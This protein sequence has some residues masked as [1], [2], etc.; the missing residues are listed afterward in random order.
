MSVKPE[1]TFISGIHKHLPPVKAFHREKMNNPY[2]SGT[3][4]VWYSANR[5]LWV[6]YKFIPKLPVRVPVK[7]GLSPLQRDWL[8]RRY[9]EGRNVWVIVGHPAGGVIL[10]DL[11]WNDQLLTEVFLKHSVD[12]KQLAQAILE[13]CG[14]LTK[15]SI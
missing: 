11:R 9:R 13:N 8:E 7:I 5:D 12:R 10:K 15:Y 4:D 1:T 6:E 2:S 14:G 3:A